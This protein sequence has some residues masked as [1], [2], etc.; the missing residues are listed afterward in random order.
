[1][2]HLRRELFPIAVLLALAAPAHAS[3]I[4]NTTFDSSLDAN[5]SPLEVTQWKNAIAYVEGV[6]SGLFTNSITINLTVE[7]SPGT[8][9]L[10]ESQT[11]LLCC[12]DY[13]TTAAALTT[14]A[15]TPDA[16]TAAANLPSTDPTGGANFWFPV[17]EARALNLYPASNGTA[18]G[19]V[20][21][22]AG[23]DYTFDPGDSGVVG[24]Y[25][26]IGVAEHEI[27]E[28][29]GRIGLLGN[30]A[31]NGSP[32]FDPLDLFGYTAPG[33]LSLNQTSTGVYFSIDGG[34]SAL[35]TYNDPGNGGDL[36]DWAS[37]AND[38][39]NAFSNSGVENGLSAA[40]LTEMNVIGYTPATVPEPSSMV[41]MLLVGFAA[42]VAIRRRRRVN[43]LE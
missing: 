28:V 11:N 25:D 9:I 27:S 39:Y 33:A 23:F 43:A 32:A 13:A 5:L 35:M 34:N 8:S 17:A 24:D 38:S 31:L 41:P 22:G 26:F 4:F 36:R 12:L 37:G 30:T 29:M 18:D 21:F 40:D 1:M 7:A 14:T 42:V 10:G 20:T 3:L 2:R 19:T 6:Y 16:I 15:T